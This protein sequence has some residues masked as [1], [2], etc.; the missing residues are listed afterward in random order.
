MENRVPN[1][2]FFARIKTPKDLEERKNQNATDT[3]A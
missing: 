3:G 2:G 1:L